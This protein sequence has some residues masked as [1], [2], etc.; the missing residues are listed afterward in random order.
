MKIIFPHRV[1]V[2]EAFKSLRIPEL[3]NQLRLCRMAETLFEIFNMV[4]SAR[5]K[6]RRDSY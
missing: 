2:L 3:V 1:A 5:E 4:V 6:N